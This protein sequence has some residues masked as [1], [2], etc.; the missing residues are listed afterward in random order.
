MYKL[1]KPSKTEFKLHKRLVKGEPIEAK[2]RRM[3]NNREP[4]TEGADASYT[5]REEGV[6]PEHDPRTDKQEL[7]LDTIAKATGFKEAQREMRKGEKT[8][9]T[10]T[11]EQ[12]T[13]F[14][15]KF[16]D[17]KHAKAAKTEG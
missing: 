7:A 16:P 11:P 1:I 9:D 5:E 12:Q 4:L 15:T 13:E 8:Y 14:N 6:R 3:K 2:I 17:N 10:M